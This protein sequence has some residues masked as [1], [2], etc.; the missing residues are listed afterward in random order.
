ML[1]EEAG[2]NPPPFSRLAYTKLSD[3]LNSTFFQTSIALRPQLSVIV[4]G[5]RGAGKRS[6]IEGI[7]DDIGFNIIT[8]SSSFNENYCC[9]LIQMKVDCYDIIGDTPAVTSGTLLA[10]LSKSISCSPSLLVLHHVEALSSKSDSPLGRPPPIVRVLEEV[11]DGASQTSN[12]NS[13]SSSSW[14][15][16]VIGTT[17]DADAVPSEVLACFKQEIELKAPNEEERLAI[18]KYKLEGY[19]VAPDV[20]VR[21]L[22]RQTAAL[23]A[24]DIDSFVHLAWNAAVKR[25]TSSCVSFPQAQQ[26]GISI[27]DEDFTHALS[28]TRAAYSDSIGAPKIPNVSWDDVGGLVSVKQDILDTIQLPLE[29]PEMFGEGLKKRSG[30]S[31]N[32]IY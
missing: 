1:I 16:F 15:V 19:E 6:L 23:N 5:A 32:I 27:T 29:R 8:V 14:P 28:K 13:E 20:D 7:A 4:K 3:I 26:A 31:F 17:A 2:S 18:I 11:I 9:D 21:A 25:S 30:K 22:A 12:S 10:R 24:G